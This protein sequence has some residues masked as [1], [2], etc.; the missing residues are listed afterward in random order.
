MNFYGRSTIEWKL[1]CESSS[2]LDRASIIDLL[3]N[4]QVEDDDNYYLTCAWWVTLFV[5]I[6]G[7]C[8]TG[9]FAGLL[10]CQ[11]MT[12]GNNSFD[13][14]AVLPSVCSICCTVSGALAVSL[15]LAAAVKNLDIKE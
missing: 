5:L 2:G 9:I 15:T 1:S 14:N 7:S 3:S 6:L 13:F 10:N 11:C 8:C 12:R 4:A